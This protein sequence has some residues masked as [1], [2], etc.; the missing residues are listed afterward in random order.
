MEKIDKKNETEVKEK[1]EVMENEEN[2]RELLEKNL[3]WS[4]IIYEQ[5]RRLNRQLFW[6]S[7]FGWVKLIIIIAPLVVGVWYFWPSIKNVQQQY[8]DIIELMNNTTSSLNNG[9]VQIDNS[10]VDK[11]LKMLP[12]NSGMEEQFKAMIK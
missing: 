9:K 11:I 7:I 2:L 1:K 12:L 6:N 3:K 10:T 5:T 4:Q 8:V